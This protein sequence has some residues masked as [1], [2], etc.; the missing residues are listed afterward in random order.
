MRRARFLQR[1]LAASLGV[2]F[3]IAVGGQAV[4]A[5]S[6]PHHETRGHSE[7]S[8]EAVR[9][10]GDTPSAAADGFGVRAPS[11]SDPADLPD[12]PC[13][14]IGTCHPGATAA[15]T[16]T[17]SLPT[18]VVPSVRDAEPSL[19]SLPL[20]PVRESGFLLHLPNAPPV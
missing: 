10:A 17:A 3:A 18:P 1:G 6:C 9:G 14:C 13:N 8:E 19:P 12:H 20:P 4:G 5:R 15:T 7:S 11:S 2:L 16:N